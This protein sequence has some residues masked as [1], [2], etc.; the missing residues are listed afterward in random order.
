MEHRLSTARFGLALAALVALGGVAH[1]GERPASDLVI[2]GE[3]VAQR[4]CG[5]CHAVAG[6][7]ASPLALAPP[8]RDIHLRYRAG[9]LEQLLR[10][11]ML[12]PESMPEEGSPPRHPIMPMIDLGVDEVAEL[13]AYLKSL[14]PPARP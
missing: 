4:N 3:R 9:G 6:E 12:Q 7:G 8:F 11:G 10:E 13:T 2:A 5:G 14:E 1:A